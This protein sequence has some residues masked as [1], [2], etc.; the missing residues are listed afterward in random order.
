MPASIQSVEARMHYMK[1]NGN[2]F[3]GTAVKLM[4]DA[5]EKVTT[6]IGL[7]GRT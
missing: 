5:A 3:L 7:K 4:A 2:E 6:P 1:M